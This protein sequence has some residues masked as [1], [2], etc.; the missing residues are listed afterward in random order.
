MRGVAVKMIGPKE[1]HEAFRATLGRTWLS[2]S[3]AG[4]I[5]RFVADSLIRDRTFPDR[6]R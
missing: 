5:F 3:V 4:A 2:V 6:P 1:K